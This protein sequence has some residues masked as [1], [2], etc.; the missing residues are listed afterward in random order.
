M[1]IIDIANHTTEVYVARLKETIVM[2]SKSLKIIGMSL[3]RYGEFD[4][5]N[6]FTPWAEERVKSNYGRK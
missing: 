4:R 5:R 6:T 1:A 3:N 2:Q